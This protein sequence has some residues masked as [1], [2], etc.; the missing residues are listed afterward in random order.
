MV[1]TERVTLYGLPIVAGRTV[2]YGRIDPAVSRELF[3]RRALVEGEWETRHDF[4][5]ANTALVEEVEAMEERARRRDILVPDQVRYDFFDARIPADVVSGTH[6]DRWWRDERRRN[7]DLLSYTREL[8]VN[9]AAASALDPRARPRA[10]RQGELTLPLSYRFEPGAEHDGVTVHVPLT[11]LG[12][13]RQEGFEWL[14]P[15]FRTELVTAL[16]RSLPKDLRRRLVPA[17]DVAAQVV[18]RLEPRREPL[19][20]ALSGTIERLRGVRIPRDAWDP[21]RLPSHLRM[22]FRVEDEDGT[23][24]AEG[25]DVEALRAE[26]RPRLRERLA[27][28]TAGLERR[29]LRS[30]TL[31]TLPR[32]VELPGAG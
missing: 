4:F 19:L 24:L 22:A 26:V 27:S 20:D 16:I 18:E 11:A 9:P 14:V 31:G 8:L 21:S 13:L 28:A 25:H 2:A 7:P 30:W 3:I 23:V 15:A 10:W 1:A 17:P 32:T 5:H 29:G 6:F 12:E